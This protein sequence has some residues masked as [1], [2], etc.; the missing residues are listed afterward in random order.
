MP[1]ERSI[2]IWR[3]DEPSQITPRSYLLKTFGWLAEALVDLG[4]LIQSVTLPSKFAMPSDYWTVVNR[5]GGRGSVWAPVVLGQTDKVHTVESCNEAAMQ[6]HQM[7]KASD[8]LGS[9]H[10]HARG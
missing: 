4:R 8:V 5:D 6:Q 10:A 2:A 3:E 9:A 7:G 1:F